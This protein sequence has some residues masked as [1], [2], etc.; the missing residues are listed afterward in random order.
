VAATSRSDCIDAAIE[1]GSRSPEPAVLPHGAWA[2]RDK[3]HRGWIACF[4]V[5]A[6]S[7]EHVRDDRGSV[8]LFSE[9]SIA[10]NAALWAH[11]DRQNAP[12]AAVEGV[13][14]HVSG[15]GRYKRVSRV[16]GKRQSKLTGWPHAK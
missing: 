1:A 13:K 9:K 11:I 5:K 7:T 8:R 6:G 15:S 4:S 2:M 10:L 14:H 12:L 16:S 3:F